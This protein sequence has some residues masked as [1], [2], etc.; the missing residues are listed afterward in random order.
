MS[1]SAKFSVVLSLMILFM[2]L[3]SAMNVFGDEITKVFEAK[4]RV[5]IN[6]VSGDCI[7]KKGEA[8]EIVATF[9]QH[10]RPKG[11]MKPKFTERSSVL[12]LKEVIKGSS[13]GDSRWIVYV[14]EGTEIEFTTA[15]GSFH[16][17]D[18]NGD[19]RVNTASGDIEIHDCSGVFDINTASGDIDASGIILEDDAVFGTASGTVRV[20][21]AET[22]EYD[23]KIGS[24]SGRAILMYNGH[25]VKGNFEFSCRPG[26]GRIKAPY[27]FDEEEEF[28][29][30]GQ[31]YVRKS[32][33]RVDSEP[34]ISIGTASGRA[35]MEK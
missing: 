16:V 9:I 10:T 2:V 14:P 18:M 19:F 35:I 7:I 23:L 5:D 3:F 31:R 29:R 24:A 20:D 1:K 30:S 4:K 11:A 21:L 34:H 28:Y 33:V 25:E 12:K 17:E 32:F 6:T 27:D 8:G 15:S 22:P 26:H 13:S